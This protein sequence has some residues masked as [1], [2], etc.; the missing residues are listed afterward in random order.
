MKI[1]FSDIDGVLNCKRTTN[2]R[3]FPYVADPLLVKRFC[4]VLE[5]TRSEVVL[6]ST[7]RYD[8]AGLFSAQYWRIP[9]STSRLTSRINLGAMRSF[10]VEQPL[11]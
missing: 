9:S 7:W 4:G 10:M 1:V 8:P 3:K 5:R 2:P 11:Q 6:T